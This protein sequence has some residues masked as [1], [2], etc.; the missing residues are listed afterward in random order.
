MTSSSS[1]SV[2]RDIHCQCPVLDTYLVPKK[3][4]VVELNADPTGQNVGGQLIVDGKYEFSDLDELI[5]NHV[6]ALARRVEELMAFEKFK[7]GPEDELRLYCF[8]CRDVYLI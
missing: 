6:Q 3:I 2:S 8:G 5:V 4:D 1:T 7:P